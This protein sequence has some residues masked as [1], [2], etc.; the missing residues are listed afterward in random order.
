MTG[1]LKDIF[2]RLL[3]M[4][5]LIR[6]RKTGNAVEFANKIKISERQLYTYISLMKS[7]GAP[8][9]YSRG[10]GS[11][12]YDAPGKFFIGYDTTSTLA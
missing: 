8:I 1:T 4:D 5:R 3:E 12:F 10:R 9:I 7:M 11:Y 2:D 6:E